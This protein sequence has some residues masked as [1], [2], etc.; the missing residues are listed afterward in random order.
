MHDWA[1][2]LVV[3]DVEIMLQHSN[4]DVLKLLLGYDSALNRKHLPLP[5]H[6]FSP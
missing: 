1:P 2:S 4:H 5:Y 3:K 6:V